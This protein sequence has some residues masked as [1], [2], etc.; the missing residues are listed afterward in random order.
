MDWQNTTYALVQ[1][2]HNFGAV[3]VV[4]TPS[5]MLW[6]ARHGTVPGR[7]PAWLV[8]CGWALQGASGAAF[9]AT[10]YYWYGAL[11]DIHGVAVAALAIKV[12]CALAGVGLAGVLLVGRT[13]DMQS[14]HRR[15]WHWLLAAGV[16]ALTAAA[17]LRWFS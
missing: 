16:T 7:A 13:G 2:A 8:L 10:S 9:G 1:V 17:F 4:G 12:A 6:A 5:F 11:P 3:A 14:R 15:C